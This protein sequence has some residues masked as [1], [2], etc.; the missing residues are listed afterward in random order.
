MIP[1]KSQRVSFTGSEG[2]QLGGIL[3]EPET[4]PIGFIL[5]AHCFTCSKDLKA[6]VRISRGLAALG[7]GVLRFDFA[8]LG[9]SHGDF[10]QTNF[11]TNRIDLIAA[12]HYLKETHQAPCMIVGHSFGGAA[13]MSV[14]NQI[15]SIRCIVALAAP[16]E[17][18]HLADVLLQMDPKIETEGIGSVT[19]GGRTFPIARQMIDDFRSY[20]LTKDLAEL[21]KPLMI[22]HSPADTTVGYHHAMRIYSLVMH[23]NRK[24]AKRPEV[25]LLTLPQSDH[26][27]VNNPHDIPMIVAWTS[28][29][30]K[31]MMS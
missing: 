10:A 28:A 9:H 7:W 15:D 27:L 14:A 22:L 31:R 12:S 4:Q 2:R 21:T 1:I 13:A 30:G 25:S 5:M 20:D 29:W 18:S 3:D 17:T 11:Q 24:D 23:A 26:L 8:G 19:I 6:S 16:S